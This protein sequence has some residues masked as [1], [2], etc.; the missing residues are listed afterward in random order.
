M[1]NA[2]KIFIFTVI[3]NFS[4]KLQEMKA[5][6]ITIDHHFSMEKWKTEKKK[7]SYGNNA[8]ENLHTNYS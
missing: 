8:D 2:N 1:S 4:T 5:Y 6:E 3:M 7:P